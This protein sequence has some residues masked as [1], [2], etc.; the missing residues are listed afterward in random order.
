MSK[1]KV[2]RE[3]RATADRHLSGWWC[4]WYCT[5]SVFSGLQRERG[6]GR[7]HGFSDFV[8]PRRISALGRTALGWNGA[9]LLDITR[10]GE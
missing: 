10:A 1:D 3:W 7:G 6:T 2:A 9:T 5:T 8:A 4:C